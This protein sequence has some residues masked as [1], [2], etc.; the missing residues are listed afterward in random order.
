MFPTFFRCL[1]DYMPT[2]F[3]FVAQTSQV[4][5]YIFSAVGGT[6]KFLAS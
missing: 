6:M 3:F 5:K 1:K 2:V 4:L